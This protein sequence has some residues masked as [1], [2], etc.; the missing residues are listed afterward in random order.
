M[1]EDK[2]GIKVYFGCHGNL[3]T[4]AIWYLPGAHY[5]RKASTKYEF[6]MT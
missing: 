1:I 5:S 2:E 6:S 3:T 4:M